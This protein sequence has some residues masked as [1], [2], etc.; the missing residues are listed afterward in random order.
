M[1]TCLLHGLS[2]CGLPIQWKLILQRL[3]FLPLLLSVFAL[4]RSN[5]ALCDS[6]V[7]AVF[8]LCFDTI[9]QIHK[10]YFKI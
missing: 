9:M 7:I 5:Q 6:H 10:I 8:L 1:G 4:G 3:S 2:K